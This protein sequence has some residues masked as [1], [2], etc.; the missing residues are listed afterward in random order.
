MTRKS[1][2]E[3]RGIYIFSAATYYNHTMADPLL[4][5]VMTVSLE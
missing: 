3:K 5:K 1:P 2:I 4:I